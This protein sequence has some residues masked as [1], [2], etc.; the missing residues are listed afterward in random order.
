MLYPACAAVDLLP[1]C[2][3]EILNL[4][5]SLVFLLRPLGPLSSLSPLPLCTLVSVPV[6]VIYQ[7]VHFTNP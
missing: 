3:S 7:L 4:E 1:L 2:F 6:T 5:L